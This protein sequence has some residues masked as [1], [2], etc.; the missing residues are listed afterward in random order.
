MTQEIKVQ[1]RI[2]SR[3]NIAE[4]C[5]LLS[6]N[7]Q[8]NRRKISIELCRKWQ[9]EDPAGRLKDIACRTMLRKLEQ[10]G[11]FTLPVP[12]HTGHNQS[13]GKNFQ[14]SLHDTTVIQKPITETGKIVIHIADTG[15]DRQLW[16]TFMTSYHYLGF[17]TRVGKSICYLAKTQDSQPVAAI[18]FGAAA[19]KV[20]SRDCY[21]GWNKLERE[22]NLDKIVNNHRFLI[23]PWIQ[24]PHLASHV[25]SR[26]L[27]RLSSDWETKYGHPVVLAE[28]FVEQARFKGTC[29]KA[30]NWIHLGETTGRTRN[31]V[32]TCIHAPIK[33]VLVYPLRKDFR[34]H[35]TGSPT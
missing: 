13:R 20:A 5:D 31:D 6:Q 14:P 2:L 19:W 18:L 12:R 7:P 16:Q 25:L 27:R 35:L 21:I 3:E 8:W 30:A 34:R 32:H 1:G 24:V 11:F 4:I 15:M 29:Y 28:T 23:L 33:S 17:Q 22:S 10:K 9:W 26:V